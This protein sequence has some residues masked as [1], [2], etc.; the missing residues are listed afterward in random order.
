MVKMKFNKN[1]LKT[2][3]LIPFFLFPSE[4]DKIKVVQGTGSKYFLSKDKGL[5]Q[6]SKLAE[7]NNLEDSYFW[8]G[9]YWYDVG[10]KSD[11]C[12]STKDINLIKRLND[13]QKNGIY[14][15]I[16]PKK[17]FTKFRN[18]VPPSSRDLSNLKNNMNYLKGASDSKGVWYFDWKEIPESVEKK[19]SILQEY[20]KNLRLFFSREIHNKNFNPE[21]EIKNLEEKAKELGIYLKYEKIR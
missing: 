3:A 16:H 21:K 13:S 5:Y 14:T 12:S 9:K 8:D 6:I 18:Y 11:E 15:H 19:D 2:L 20:R 17:L 4:E 10:I 1:L 7:E